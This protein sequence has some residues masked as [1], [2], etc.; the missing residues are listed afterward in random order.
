MI[1]IKRL[2]RALLITLVLILVCFVIALVWLSNAYTK[3]IESYPIESTISELR[4][5]NNYSPYEDISEIFLDSIVAVEDHRFYKHGPVDIIG[6]GR[7]FI[8]NIVSQEIEQGG[9]TITQQLAK[10]L[11]LSHEQT[12]ERKLKEMFIAHRLEQLYTKKEILELYVNIINYGDGNVGI[13][14]AS[15]NY[16]DSAPIE[17][18][19]DEAT[20]LAGLPQAPSAYALSSNYDLALERQ[21][22][23]IDALGEFTS[24][25]DSY[26]NTESD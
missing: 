22:Q 18:S 19:F 2:K 15:T 16:F 23:V 24:E 3:T 12:I 20:M 17:L 8:T 21:A 26:I 25:Y 14:M 10:N 4:N 6:T 1:F 13:K 11:F 9:S 5:S 7:A